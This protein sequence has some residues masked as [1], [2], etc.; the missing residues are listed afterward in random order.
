MEIN[1]KTYVQNKDPSGYLNWENLSWGRVGPLPKQKSSEPKRGTK[2]LQEGGE[3]CFNRLLGQDKREPEAMCWKP[4][5]K[6]DKPLN[7]QIDPLR[8]LSLWRNQEARWSTNSM[9]LGFQTDCVCFWWSLWQGDIML[10]LRSLV[11]NPSKVL[12]LFLRGTI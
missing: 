5:A 4:K 8:R 2:V 7:L 6:E 11:S 1:Q 12:D 9:N 3:P 10:L